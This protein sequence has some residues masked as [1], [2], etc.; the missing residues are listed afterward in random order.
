MP[1]A[2]NLNVIAI[3]AC[4]SLWRCEWP[5]S[6]MSIYWSLKR[7]MT[8]HQRVDEQQVSR[9]E[10]ERASER[11]RE[12]ERE[13]AESPRLQFK[14]VYVGIPSLW[15]RAPRIVRVDSESRLLRRFSTAP[16]PVLALCS[17]RAAFARQQLEII[18]PMYSRGLILPRNINVRF[19]EARVLE[20]TAK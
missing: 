16:L 15:S 2:A 11:A 12:R 8:E 13:R 9:H 4:V 3:F 6:L 17:D 7:R 14:P 20:E 10:R 18:F 5:H 1:P 19:T